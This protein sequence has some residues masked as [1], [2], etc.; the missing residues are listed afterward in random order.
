VSRARRNGQPLTIAMVDVDHFKT[1]N[2]RHGHAA[3]DEVLRSIASALGGAFR[4]TDIVGRYG[5][6]EFVIAMPETNPAAG[7][8]KLEDFRQL[9]EGIPIQTK[10]GDTVKV[11]ISAGLAGFP[12]DGVHEEE[13]LAVADARL[14]EAKGSGRN[15]IV[16]EAP[17]RH[18]EW[19]G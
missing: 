3:G 15:R 14:F 9:I 4:K 11:T 1:F 10:R 2:D 8:R 13:V 12:Q 6:E 5:G 19:L 7:G 18:E 16:P 17:E